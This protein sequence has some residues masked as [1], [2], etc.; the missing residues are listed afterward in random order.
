VK[1]QRPTPV[2][3]T[4]ALVRRGAAAFAVGLGLGGPACGELASS[5]DPT[6]PQ[7][8]PPQPD[9]EKDD[10]STPLLDAGSDAA[11]GFDVSL[12][13]DVSLDLDVSLG[14]DEGPDPSV[15]GGDLLDAED[16]V[17]PHPILPP[18]R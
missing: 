9:P 16:D 2:P 18:P 11:L 7:P 17:R 3:R 8:V 6:P 15:D 12:G 10:A 1:N 4:P 5:R 14:T 13:L